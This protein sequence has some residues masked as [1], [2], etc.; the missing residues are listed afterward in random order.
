MSGTKDEYAMLIPDWGYKH[1]EHEVVSYD[2]IDFT[3]KKE[4]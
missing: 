3:G 4:Y 1:K 2:D